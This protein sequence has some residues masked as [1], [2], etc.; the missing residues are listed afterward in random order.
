M[1]QRHTRAVRNAYSKLLQSVID[2]LSDRNLAQISR[3]IGLH[4]NTIRGIANG[5]NRNPSLE[6]LDL[7][8][9]YL[10]GGK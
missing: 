2:G 1:G 4:E 10:F 5:K 7:L 6:T 8:A 9:D 3:A